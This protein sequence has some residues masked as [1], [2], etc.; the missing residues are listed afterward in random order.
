M[1]ISPSIKFLFSIKISL[2]SVTSQETMK[3]GAS[4][5]PPLTEAS[6]EFFM[7]HL[8]RLLYKYDQDADVI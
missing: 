8:T 1:H 7:L 2:V 5:S 4:D 6:G 3:D